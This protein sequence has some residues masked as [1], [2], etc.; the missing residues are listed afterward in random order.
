[1]RVL[2]TG[3]TGF[4]GSAIVEALRTTRP[5][6]ELTCM[7]RR[8][9]RPSPWGAAVRLVSGDV[10]DPAS[11][12]RAVE[13]MDAVVHC[14][15]FPNHP[16]ENPRRGYTYEAIDGQGTV[17]VAAACRA[18]GV[19]RLVYLSGAGVRPGRTEPWFR[20]KW[21][22]EEA[23]RGFG[24]EW[25]IFRP[26]WVYG[27][28]DRSLNR[29][30]QLVRLLPVVPV[31][32][33]GRNRVQPV[34]VGDVGEVVARGVVEPRAAGQVFEL[35]GPEHLTMDE[36]LRTVQRLLGRHQPLV[37]APVALVKLQA[38]LLALLP[39]P[40]LSPAAI[41]FILME[42]TVDPRPAEALFGITFRRLEDSLR[43]YLGA[44]GPVSSQAAHP[45]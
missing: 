40:P 27:R 21:T 4:I 15:Q 7:T 32:G 38:S 5:D 19:R 16:V 26:S 41:D 25:V 28:Q 37:H 1:M 24:G 39:D 43:T 14:V 42:E 31:I 3:G 2:V 12:R 20:A 29:F 45:A 33:N 11:L 8:A 23:V 9:N 34:F 35:G 10:R 44:R 22:A 17:N 36:I 6:D 30:I 18:A 13:G